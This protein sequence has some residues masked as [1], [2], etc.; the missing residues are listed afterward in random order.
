MNYKSILAEGGYTLNED[1]PEDCQ[2]TFLGF[3][4]GQIKE[5]AKV[6]IIDGFVYIDMPKDE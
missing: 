6:T 3:S 5:N 4:T 1:I 2:R